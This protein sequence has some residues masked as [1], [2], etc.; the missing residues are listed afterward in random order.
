VSSPGISQNL[1]FL[2]E[3]FKVTIQLTALCTALSLPLGALVGLARAAPI[4]L[5]RV[6]GTAYVEFLRNIPPLILLFFFFFGLPSTGVTID[7]FECGVLA[8][9]L[10]TSAFVAEIVR[11]GIAAVE[12]GQ[13]DAV[14]SLGFGYFGALRY[15]VLPQALAM[16]LPAMG[17][18]IVGIVKNTALVASIGVTDL[19]HQGEV[20]ESHTFATFST[21]TTVALLYLALIVPMSS[22]VAVLDRRRMRK[23]R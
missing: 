7:D 23:V 17:N 5:L 1:S 10:Y 3:G 19:M 18:V 6:A 13:V 8:L 16:A 14:R 11:A 21:F 20:L 9:T 12:R 22:A 4:K 2:L 15:V